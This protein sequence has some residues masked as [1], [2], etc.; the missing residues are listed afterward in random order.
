MWRKRVKMLHENNETAVASASASGY[1]SGSAAGYSSGNADGIEEGI[2]VASDELSC[3][4][5]MDVA[6]PFC[7]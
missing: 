5:D 7:N 2:D 4:D 3:S 1:S 6:L